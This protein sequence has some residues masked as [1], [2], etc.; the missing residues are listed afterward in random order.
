MPKFG[1]INIKVSKDKVNVLKNF[2][3]NYNGY[4]YNEKDECFIFNKKVYDQMKMKMKM[5]DENFNDP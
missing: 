3:Y 5:E 1:G 4:E 2:L